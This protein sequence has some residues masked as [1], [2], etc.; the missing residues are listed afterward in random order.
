MSVFFLIATAA[1]IG[2]MVTITVWTKH[3]TPPHAV[4]PRIER[5]GNGERWEALK[6][7]QETR[8]AAEE[9]RGRLTETLQRFEHRGES[10][11]GD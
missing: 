6:M 9:H 5:H 2:A 10:K 1:L 7:T 4:V 8:R 3:R 11:S